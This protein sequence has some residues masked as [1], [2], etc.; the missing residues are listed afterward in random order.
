MLLF[1]VKK[2]PELMYINYNSNINVGNIFL[3]QLKYQPSRFPENLILDDY[4][5]IIKC[6]D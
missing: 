6:S 3:S 5:I 1:F 4:T 2:N